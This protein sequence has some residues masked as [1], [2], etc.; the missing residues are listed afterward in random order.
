MEEAWSSPT[1][2]PGGSLVAEKPSQQRSLG[3][4]STHDRSCAAPRPRAADPFSGRRQVRVQP[5]FPPQAPS[6]RLR[7]V[8][9]DSTPGAR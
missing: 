8:L 7:A 1:W 4:R 9:R 5:S 2:Q 3:F 6:R